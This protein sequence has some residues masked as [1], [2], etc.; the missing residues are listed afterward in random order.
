M[1]LE[2]ALRKIMRLCV[3]VEGQTEEGFVNRV[4]VPYLS[5]H[6]VYPSARAVETGRNR[7]RRHRGGV[8]SYEK[9]KGDILEWMKED[10]NPDV[11][12]TTMI[13]FYGLRKIAEFPGLDE[14]LRRS[15]P[16]ERV[17]ILEERFCEN[18]SSARD[19]HRFIPY[20]QLHEFEALLLA[21][22]EALRSEFLEREPEIGRLIREVEALDNPELINET[23]E[24]APSKRIIRHIPEYK[25]KKATAGPELTERIGLPT[26]RARCRHFDEW[27]SKLEGLGH[28]PW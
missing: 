4:L 3:V 16:Y 25:G 18:V 12:F 15:D 2:G 28:Q 17:A 27:I 5:G 11:R 24:N 14:A 8:V 19:D 13:D 1:C 6:G 20:L 9:L 26:L 22:P 7:H 21:A 23:E 10:R